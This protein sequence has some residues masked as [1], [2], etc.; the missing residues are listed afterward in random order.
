MGPSRRLR[1]LYRLLLAGSAKPSV[2]YASLLK[3]I[4]RLH[5]VADLPFM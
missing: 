3:E 5:L 1:H 2:R 4:R